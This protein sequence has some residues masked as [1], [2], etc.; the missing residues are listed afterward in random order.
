MRLAGTQAAQFGQKRPIAK[1]GLRQRPCFDLR[2]G[3]IE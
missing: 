1:G 2:G 3:I